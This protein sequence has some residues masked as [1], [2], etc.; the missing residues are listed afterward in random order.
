MK[1]KKKKKKEV[2]DCKFSVLVNQRTNVEVT[3]IIIH[4]NRVK[5]VK[6]CSYG[7][8]E[9]RKLILKSV[10]NRRISKFRNYH[11]SDSWYRRTL[12]LSQSKIKTSFLS[13]HKSCDLS[14]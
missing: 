12:E 4:C 13:T 14:V 8:S 7:I 5:N 2:K 11:I 1:L 6:I 3:K 10:E 9:N